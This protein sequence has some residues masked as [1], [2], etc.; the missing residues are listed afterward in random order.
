MLSVNDDR[1][2][3]RAELVWEKGT[4]RCEFHRG[5]VQKY[6]WIETGSSF[7]M[8][9]ISA[10]FLL[11]QIEES[12]SIINHRKKQWELYY[13]FLKELE[14]KNL[15]KLAVYPKHSEINYS[16]FYIITNSKGE[17]EK[18]KAHL[19][20]SGIQA[21][22]HYLDLSLSPYI[23][24]TQA[25]IKRMKYINSRRYQDSILRLPLYHDLT[26]KQIHEIADAVKGYY[27]NA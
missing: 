6:E 9:D 12:R 13:Q 22:S 16:G 8:S 7:L 18:L 15:L 14:K 21:L 5:E 26:D 19:N 1:F 24:I 20:S 17:R 3:R 23:L 11:S 4:N 10:A 2:S 25:G 27:K